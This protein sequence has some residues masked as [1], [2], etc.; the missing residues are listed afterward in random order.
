MKTV[1][2]EAGRIQLPEVVRTQLGVKPGDEVILEDR[3]GEWVLKPAN[4]QTG[5]CWEGT[6]L[7]HKGMSMTS[8][9]IEDVIDQGRNDRFRLVT[10][11]FMP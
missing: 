5:L 4:T 6:V 7:V 9:T 10:D 2:D 1:V 8:G 11:G 3:A